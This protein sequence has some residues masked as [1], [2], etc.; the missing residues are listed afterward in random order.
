MDKTNSQT[1]TNDVLVRLGLV[2]FKKDA[3][4]AT[5]AIEELRK[6]GIEA[7]E[8][9]LFRFA[10]RNLFPIDELAKQYKA[11]QAEDQA[12]RRDAYPCQPE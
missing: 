3:D 8:S 7:T 4:L 1:Q 10:M 12:S 9:G 5:K 2:V 11:M 6:R